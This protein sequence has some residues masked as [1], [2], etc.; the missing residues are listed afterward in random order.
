MAQFVQIFF[1][2]Q[3]FNIK[4]SAIHQVLW[5]GKYGFEVQEGE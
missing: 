1:K 2:K 5:N 3:K 4:R